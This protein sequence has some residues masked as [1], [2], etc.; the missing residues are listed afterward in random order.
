M[1]INAG[2]APR[3]RTRLEKSAN[4][5]ALLRRDGLRQYVRLLRR[6]HR[7]RGSSKGL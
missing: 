7:F 3:S 2:P 6:L 5:W 4:E 1:P